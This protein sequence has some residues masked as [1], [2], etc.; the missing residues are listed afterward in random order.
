MYAE[1]AVFP[2]THYS[3]M[4]NENHP[5]FLNCKMKQKWYLDMSKNTVLF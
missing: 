3:E 1:N 2:I 4:Q 5:Y